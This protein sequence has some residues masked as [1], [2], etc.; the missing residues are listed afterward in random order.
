[1]INNDTRRLHLQG[2]PR[3]PFKHRMYVYVCIYIYTYMYIYIYIHMC[4]C[5]CSVFGC[6]ELCLFIVLLRGPNS[7]KRKHTY[8]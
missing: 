4:V 7:K 5:V 8:D 2:I 3:I 6:V 1:M